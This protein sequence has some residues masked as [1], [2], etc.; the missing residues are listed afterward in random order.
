MPLSSLLHVYPLFAAIGAA[1][2]I[3]GFSIGRNLASHPDVRINKADRQ[4]GYLENFKEGEQ[5]YQ[6]ALRK[7]VDGRTPHIFPGLNE[8]LGSSK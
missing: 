6:N 7:F 2:G 1:L 3:C 5:Y 8:S 4:A